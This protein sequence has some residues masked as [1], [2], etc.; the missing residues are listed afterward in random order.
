MAQS[1]QVSTPPAQ[2]Q[3]FDMQAEQEE[4]ARRRRMADI[5][6]QQ[7]AQPEG[8]MVSGRFVAPSITQR[9]A[10]LFNAY[11]GGQM[12]R[13]TTER[14]RSVNQQ[15]RDQQ[16]QEMDAVL[17][18]FQGYE[19]GGEGMPDATG[20]PTVEMQQVPGNPREALR[21]AL[22]SSSPNVQQL[23]NVLLA[24][25]LKT[26]ES[27]FAKVNPKDFTPDSVRAFTQ[28]G[29]RDFSLLVPALDVKWL[30][31]GR[32]LIATNPQTGQPI[33]GI[34][35]RRREMTPDA[36]GRI[37][38]DQFQ[39]QNLSPAQREQFRLSEAGNNIAA[40]N[41]GVSQANLYYNTGMAPGGGAGAGR[42]NLPPNAP[43]P[44]IGGGMPQPPMP[45]G[46]APMPQPGMPSGTAPMPQVV[47]QAAPQ[48]GAQPR[49]AS[50]PQVMPGQLPRPGVIGQPPAQGAVPA[51]A[52][53]GLTPKQQ[54]EM[55]EEEAKRK[56]AA[57]RGAPGTIAQIGNTV[58]AID[59]AL[60]RA[61]SFNT[62]FTGAV[63]GMIPGT[64]AYDLRQDVTTIK[65]NLGF[66]EL[67]KMREASPTGGALGAIAVQEL[68]ALQST[69]RSLNPNQSQAT[70]V[71]NLEKVRNHYLTWAQTVAQANG[72][73]LPDAPEFQLR[74]RVGGGAG[75]GDLAAQAAAELARRRRN[76]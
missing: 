48:G 39:W 60:G 64:G 40:G 52:T 41:L 59:T 61:T 76:P 49:P 34:A 25:S 74:P 46:T 38:W 71:A 53:P 32:E 54:A 68:E 55:A 66:S 7:S 58:G 28:G 69:L 43:M 19:R 27:P 9:L 47:P 4:I 21:L 33:E 16:G 11:Q 57:A 10:G 13:E 72:M 70:I 29:G 30:D 8:Q 62:G 51:A 63:A 45:G 15:F 22:R 37:A 73:Q 17:R 36:T 12:D 50:V 35:P 44:Q 1:F 3:A 6:R 31:T 18:T 67:Q 24:Q 75:G 26:P 14:Q 23:G 65:A 42:P 2:A 56:A 5:L 20:N